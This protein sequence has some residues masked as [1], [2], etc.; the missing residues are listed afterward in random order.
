[1]AFIIILSGIVVLFI[2]LITIFIM[3][4]KYKFDSLDDN[5]KEINQMLSNSIIDDEII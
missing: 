3:S 1:M 2:L 4:K 5:M